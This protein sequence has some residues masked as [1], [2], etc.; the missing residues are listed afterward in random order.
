MTIST[1]RVQSPGSWEICVS[2]FSIYSSSSSRRHRCNH[3]IKLRDIA[4]KLRRERS[5]VMAL[6]PPGKRVLFIMISL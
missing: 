5:K 2:I 6:C 1:L 4:V 3:I